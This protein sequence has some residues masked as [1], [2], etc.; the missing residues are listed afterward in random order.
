MP[1]MRH[2]DGKLKIMHSIIGNFSKTLRSV[3]ALESVDSILTG[4]ISP[5]KSYREGLTF[6]Y[7]TDNGL[8][9]LAKTTTAV[10]EI[11]VVTREPEL[12]LDELE[13]SGLI[14]TRRDDVRHG[15]SR[16]RPP[17]RPGDR[18]DRRRTGW[19]A[20][21]DPGPERPAQRGDD[22][23]TVRQLLPADVAGKLDRLRTVSSTAQ[24]PPDPKEMPG[25]AALPGTKGEGGNPGTGKKAPGK[26]DSEKR[27]GK[28]P[29]T[30]AESF[31][32]LFEPEEDAETFEELLNRSRLDPKHFK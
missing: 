12:V 20:P 29:Q 10:Q 3:A 30:K 23:V 11:F 25:R 32:D 18:R 31:R 24:T 7:F 5:S 17:G 1:D 13:K 15:P 26:P 8:K 28:A 22:P 19:N 2:R 9:L 16:K 14:D 27:S 21:A 4:T 6:Q